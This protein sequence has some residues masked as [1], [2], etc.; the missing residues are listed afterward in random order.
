MNLVMTLVAMRH[1]WA[2]VIT[3]FVSALSV[4]IL[5][6]V[7]MVFMEKGLLDLPNMFVIIS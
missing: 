7:S 2:N 4:I 3:F 5:I 1:L 6:L